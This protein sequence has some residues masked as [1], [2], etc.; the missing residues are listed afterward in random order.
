MKFF[1]R[2]EHGQALYLVEGDHYHIEFD[3][4][5]KQIFNFKRYN[6]INFSFIHLEIEYEKIFYRNFNAHVALLG[7]SFFVRYSI[8]TQEQVEEMEEVD[9]R[10][11]RE[12]KA[13][14]AMRSLVRKLADSGELER[15][16]VLEAKV[17][18]E[19]MD[20]REQAGGRRV[21]DMTG[22]QLE[23]ILRGDS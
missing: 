23:D 10:I 13:D 7:F 20:A 4:E 3:N 22:G 21:V 12:L 11:D 17:I 6:W 16:M 1:V 15:G 18:V 9:E 14:K 5:W 8:P 19:V 2:D